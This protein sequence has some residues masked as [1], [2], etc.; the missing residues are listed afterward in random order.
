MDDLVAFLR[1]RLDEE[2]IAAQRAM[3]ELVSVTTFP[4]ETRVQMPVEV[5]LREVPPAVRE[6]IA[7][8]DPPRVLAEVAWRRAFL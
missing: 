7:R 4:P 2:D 5:R 3:D 8:W 1:D 6:H